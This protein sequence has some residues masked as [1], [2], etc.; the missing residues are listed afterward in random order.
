MG[1]KKKLTAVIMGAILAYIQMEPK[2]PE[3]KPIG[4]K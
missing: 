1:D 2:S 4:G 3:Q